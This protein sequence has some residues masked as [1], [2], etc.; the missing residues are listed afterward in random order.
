MAPTPDLLPRV[1]LEAHAV[2]PY[3][4]VC[5]WLEVPGL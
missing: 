3:G 4:K 5:P 1:G 2:R